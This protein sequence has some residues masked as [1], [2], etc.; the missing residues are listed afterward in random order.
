MYATFRP[1]VKGLGRK[2]PASDRAQRA[3]ERHGIGTVSATASRSGA[4]RHRS[5]WTTPLAPR[6][7]RGTKLIGSWI[8]W[9]DPG[10]ATFRPC[11]CHRSGF[12]RFLSSCV[13][14]D[15]SECPTLMA[16]VNFLVICFPS[17]LADRRRATPG[18]D[19]L[20][21]PAAS[22]QRRGGAILRNCNRRLLLTQPGTRIPWHESIILLTS[23]DA[24]ILSG[25]GIAMEGL[26]NP[27]HVGND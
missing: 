23:Q 24:V 22:V 16:N 18:N 26:C 13:C 3:A 10:K 4:H 2:L 11:P 20:R 14:R 9:L 1:S 12:R 6:E 15:A 19:K 27:V 8:R 25:V 5:R 17:I 7:S 21:P